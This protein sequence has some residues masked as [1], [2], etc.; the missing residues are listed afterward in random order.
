MTP[1]GSEAELVLE[2]RVLVP[3]LEFFLLTK[4][5]FK[6]RQNKSSCR[7]CGLGASPRT[8]PSWCPKCFYED[9]ISFG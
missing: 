2:P 6:Q 9:I 8:S 3:S 7:A 4:S 1:P 5:G